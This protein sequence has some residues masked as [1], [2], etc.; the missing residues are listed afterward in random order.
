MA[1]RSLPRACLLAEIPADQRGC[2][3]SCLQRSITNDYKTFRGSRL[4]FRFVYQLVIRKSIVISLCFFGQ[5]VPGPVLHK[6]PPFLE[7]IAAPV[8]GFNL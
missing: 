3:I 8:V 5:A 1:R 4:V 7:K 2:A 6:C